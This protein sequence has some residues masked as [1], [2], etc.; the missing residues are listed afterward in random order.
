MHWLIWSGAAILHVALVSTFP[1]SNFI[2]FATMLVHRSAAKV[3]MPLLLL[4]RKLYG[5]LSESCSLVWS[6][7]LSF[8]LS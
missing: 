7:A 1:P 8:P 4:V 3:S 2:R 5:S 6:E